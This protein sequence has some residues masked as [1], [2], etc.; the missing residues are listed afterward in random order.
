MTTDRISR[1]LTALLDH[2]RTFPAVPMPE[3]L[4]VEA[5][6]ALSAGRRGRS[7][8]LRIVCRACGAALDETVDG[9]CAE[10]NAKVAGRQMA[11]VFYSDGSGNARAND[12]SIVPG[13]YYQIDLSEPRG[14]FAT[15]LDA[16]AAAQAQEKV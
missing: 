16:R 11:K 15:R 7:E 5:Q 1:A 9:R 13:W 3:W 2:A 6:G 4:L 12:Q 14:P 8:N 10:C